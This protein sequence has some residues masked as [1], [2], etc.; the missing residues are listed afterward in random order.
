MSYIFNL[1]NS[2]D[3]DK[4]ILY[5]LYS[6]VAIQL[7]YYIFFYLRITLKSKL[8][9]TDSMRPL[10]VIICAKNEAEN[11]EKFLPQ[12]LNQDY[13]DFEVVVVNDCSSDDT[14][15]VLIRLSNQY[16]NLRFTTIHEDF[17]FKHGKKLALTVGIKSAKHK[18]IVLTDAD[19]YPT[20]DKWLKTI[21]N[22]FASKKEIIIAYSGFEEKKG[23]L[24]KFIRYDATTIAQNYLSFAKAGIPYMGVGR[25]L[26]YNKDLFF[27]NKGFASHYGIKSGDD[28]LFINQVAT[29]KN[30]YT[31]TDTKS[32]TKT[33]QQDSFIKWFNQK[34]RHITTANRYSLAQK[35]LLGLEPLSRV[36][37]YITAVTYF[38]YRVDTYF[39]VSVGIIAGK[40]L[41]QLII[42]K[43]VMIRLQERN[44]L[45]YSLVF[46]ILQPILY[47]L[48][49]ISNYA[50]RR[51]D[52]NKSKL[53]S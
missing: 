14:H 53:I 34:K 11:L 37:F 38:T 46:D 22:A 15:Y 1:I 48:L 6:S 43:L 36:I 2:I 16:K 51:R 30:T 41:L 24:D 12:I 7:F 3:Y 20:S 27:N 31:L 44:L 32:F 33:I 5:S 50:T 39:W 52:R 42:F 40:E 47:C 9:S 13:P 25:N 17:K 8:T 45:L 23:L 35:I 28:D 10:S 21:N 19:C 18:H 49:N 29:S 26:A 4:L